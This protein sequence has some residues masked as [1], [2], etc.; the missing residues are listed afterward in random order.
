MSDTLVVSAVIGDTG[1]C[2][3]AIGQNVLVMRNQALIETRVQVLISSMAPCLSQDLLWKTKCKEG[4]RPFGE[5]FP[6]SLHFN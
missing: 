4:H 2:I 6:L 5:F 1:L 3:C